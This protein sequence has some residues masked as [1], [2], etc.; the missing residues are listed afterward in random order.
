MAFPTTNV[1]VKTGPLGPFTISSHLDPAP[2]RGCQ[3]TDYLAA[4][5]HGFTGIRLADCSRPR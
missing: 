4:Q 2:E 5:L 1:R 3:W